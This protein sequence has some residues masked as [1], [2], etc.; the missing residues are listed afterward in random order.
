MNSKRRKIVRAK[1]SS[2]SDKLAPF[3]TQKYSVELGLLHLP[4]MTL[5]NL[6]ERVIL[7]PTDQERCRQTAEILLN[8]ICQLE[9]LTFPVYEILIDL[10]KVNYEQSKS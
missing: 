8:Q 7:T 5:L 2:I 1:R 4:L 9:P 3:L 6:S 10:K